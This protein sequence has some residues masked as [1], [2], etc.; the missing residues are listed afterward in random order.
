MTVGR[1]RACGDFGARALG[2]GSLPRVADSE[3]DLSGAHVQI[4]KWHRL[5]PGL[6]W[7][8]AHTSSVGNRSGPARR[9]EVG[10]ADKV[11]ASANTPT[12]EGLTRAG[13]GSRWWHTWWARSG[14]KTSKSEK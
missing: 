3:R 5:L 14:S 1:G 13:R 7:K 11:A 10:A 6:P 4:G 12:P 2:T 9:H 8:S